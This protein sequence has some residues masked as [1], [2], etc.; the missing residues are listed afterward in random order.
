MEEFTQEGAW[1]DL[2]WK[3]LPLVAVWRTPGN[4]TAATA[5][6]QGSGDSVLDQTGST[7]DVK[8]WIFQE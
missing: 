6:A 2:H 5:T 4:Q 1:L 3:T 7:R 8:K